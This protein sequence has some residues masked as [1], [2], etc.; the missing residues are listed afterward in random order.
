MSKRHRLLS[1]QTFPISAELLANAS[2]KLR[3]SAVLTA[4]QQLKANVGRCISRPPSGPKPRPRLAVSRSFSGSSRIS[5]RS[6][7]RSKALE[8]KRSKQRKQDLDSLAWAPAQDRLRLKSVSKT[9]LS[10]YLDCIADFEEWARAHRKS[11]SL[12]NLDATVSQFLLA[13]FESG[14]HIW[15]GS[16]LVYGLQLVR[17][18]GSDK[19]FLCN[20]KKCL[21]A[22]KRRAPARARVPM[23]EEV[24]FAIASHLL[25]QGE[26]GACLALCL[27]FD[28]Y[29]RPSETLTLRQSQLLP[30]GPKGSNAQKSWGI[31]LAPQEFGITTKT[32]EVDSSIMVGD[33]CRH[34]MFQVMAFCRQGYVPAIDNYVFPALTLARYE[35]LFAQA[36]TALGLP[37]SVTPHMV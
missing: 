20:S 36:S 4:N 27:Q 9:T 6:G 22:W 37:I 15:H 34:W 10:R 16:Y 3:S 35:K 33:V 24:I 31:M 25:E 21:K 28:T 32:G 14:W 7:S 5:T 11:T 8:R 30:P 19:E 23:P 13:G 1:N 18:R 17:N 29:M 2:K 12:L 26:L